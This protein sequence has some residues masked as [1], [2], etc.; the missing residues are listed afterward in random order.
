M[1]MQN[2]TAFAECENIVAFSKAGRKTAS[3]VRSG[4]IS[5]VKIETADG[6]RAVET[7]SEG[8]AVYTFDGDLRP[9]RRI[10]RR[11]FGADLQ[12]VYPDG[13]L[14]VPGGAMDNCEELYL[15][16]DQHLLIES[17]AADAVFGTP[18]TLLPAAALEGARGI[19]RVL[20]VDL[21]E[22]FTLIFDEDEVLYANTG[23]MMHCP[24]SRTDADGRVSPFFKTLTAEQGSALI[25]LIDAGT[26]STA[27]LVSEPKARVSVFR[28]AKSRMATA[29]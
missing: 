3:R 27:D 16:P 26:L 4:L 11:A 2:Q 28:G 29:A 23:M 12:D 25:A 8:D 9:I 14:F 13:L 24:A 5:G 6:W 1:F 10:E 21:I 19:Q 18:I 22:V 17:E 15:L 7:L 20:P